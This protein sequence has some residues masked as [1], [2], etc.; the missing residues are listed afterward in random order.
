MDPDPGGCRI[1]DSDTVM[2]QEYSLIRKIFPRVITASGLGTCGCGSI[3][4]KYDLHL[5][6]VIVLN[7]MSVG[8][9][10]YSV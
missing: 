1:L 6:L 9:S 7:E 2:W 10:I 5:N 8:M 4:M 3:I